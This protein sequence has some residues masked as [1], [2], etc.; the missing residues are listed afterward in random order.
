MPHDAGRGSAFYVLAVLFAAFVV[1]LYGPTFTILILSFQ[2]P[3]GGLT[4]P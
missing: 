3:E 2:G 1:F 4:F